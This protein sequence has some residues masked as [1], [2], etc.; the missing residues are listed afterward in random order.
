[1]QTCVPSAEHV[2]F[3]FFVKHAVHFLH[4]N[5]MERPFCQVIFPV[6]ATKTV[7]PVWMEKWRARS[8]N[9]TYIHEKIKK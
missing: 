3:H 2:S 9:L 8:H 4:R 7:F 5:A 6:F 1:M